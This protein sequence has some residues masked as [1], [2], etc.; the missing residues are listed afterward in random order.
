MFP[1]SGIAHCSAILLGSAIAVFAAYLHGAFF[2]S[3][4][5]EG[6]GYNPGDT[7]VVSAYRSVEPL[8]TSYL[9]SSLLLV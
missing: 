7:M 1:A 9:P 2:S 5:E 3:A 8:H 4:T 6:S